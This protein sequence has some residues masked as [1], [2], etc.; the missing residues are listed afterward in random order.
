MPSRKLKAQNSKLNTLDQTP[1][2]LG[3]AMPAEWEPHEATWIEWP[4]HR[5]DWPG[6]FEPIPWI[7]AE[8]VRLLARGERVHIF[9]EPS[10]Q[11][12]TRI[13]DILQRNQ[14]NLAHVTFHAQPT[15]R[16]WTR[17]TGPIFVK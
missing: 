3:Y 16:C 11:A 12:K 2:A 17:D 7:Y 5:G 10:K 1:T 4:H 6:K 8:I 13:R 15:N 9:V 14:V